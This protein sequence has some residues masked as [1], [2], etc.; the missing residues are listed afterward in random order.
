MTKS[1]SIDDLEGE[2]KQFALKSVMMI[3]ET[4]WFHT[5]D[6]NEVFQANIKPRREVEER[7]FSPMLNWVNEH[8]GSSEFV[9]YDDLINALNTDKED[10]ALVGICVNNN[11]FRN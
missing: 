10:C 8:V 1:V 11:C 6:I 9:Q 4:M 2:E 3:E 7:T 5:Y